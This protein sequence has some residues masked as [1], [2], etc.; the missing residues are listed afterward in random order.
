MQDSPSTNATWMASHL[1]KVKLPEYEKVFS[2][3]PDWLLTRHSIHVF[4]DLNNLC[5]HVEKHSL[6]A[7]HGKAGDNVILCSPPTT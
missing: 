4:K 3:V 6:A 1:G 5:K 7:E 2:M